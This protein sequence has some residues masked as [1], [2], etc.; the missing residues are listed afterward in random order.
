M[1]IVEP[2]L[3]GL[4]SP[5]GFD[6]TP[7]GSIGMNLPLYIRL[8]RVF[9]GD[10]SSRAM[11]VTSSVKSITTFEAGPRALNFVIPGVDQHQFPTWSPA[12]PGSPIVYFTPANLDQTLGLEVR[13]AFDDLDRDLYDRWIDVARQAL[14]LPVF[15][16]GP[17]AGVAGQAGRSNISRR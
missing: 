13:L 9:T 1:R 8:H 6:V 5:E 15:A 11:L 10:R 16:L 7:S 3:D 4:G 17:L 2:I 12:E 14:G